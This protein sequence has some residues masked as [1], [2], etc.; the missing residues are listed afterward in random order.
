MLDILLAVALFRAIP[1]GA[2]V[3]LAG[4]PDQ[5]PSVGP[6]NVLTKLCSRSLPEVAT[7]NVN[8]AAALDALSF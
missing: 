8:S 7:F 5:L 3:L 6:G 4:D 2:T 1:Q